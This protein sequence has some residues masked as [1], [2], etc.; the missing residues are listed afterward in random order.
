[1]QHTIQAGLILVGFAVFVAAFVFEHHQEVV[2]A[3]AEGGLVGLGCAVLTCATCISIGVLWFIA[4]AA[5]AAF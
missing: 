4:Q 5:V 3:P 1:M 2:G